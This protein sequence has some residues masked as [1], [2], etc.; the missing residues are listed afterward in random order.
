MLHNLQIVSIYFN[1]SI[2]NNKFYL[3][4]FY[5]ILNFDTYVCACMQVHVHVRV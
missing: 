1:S 3:F 2:Q 4:L 5:K